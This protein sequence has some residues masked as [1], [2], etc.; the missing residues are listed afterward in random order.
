MLLCPSRISMVYELIAAPPSVS[1]G[2]QLSVHPCLVTSD[3]FRG[4]RGAD[5]YSGNKI[6]HTCSFII[7]YLMNF[8]IINDIKYFV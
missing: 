1:G 5:G 3:T 7:K 2:S 6:T 8:T 4:P